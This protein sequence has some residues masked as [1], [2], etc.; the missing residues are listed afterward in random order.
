MEPF[1]CYVYR[2]GNGNKIVRST[3]RDPYRAFWESYYQSREEYENT[4]KKWKKTLINVPNAHW[5][6]KIHCIIINNP[7]DNKIEESSLIVSWGGEC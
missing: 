5:N 4:I 1:K 6:N 7:R 2:I 3:R